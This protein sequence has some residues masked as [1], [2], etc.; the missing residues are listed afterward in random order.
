M[1]QIFK[2]L[3]FLPYKMDFY[4]VK[5]KPF[6]SSSLQEMSELNHSFLVNY[7]L[8]FTSFTSFFSAKTLILLT[9][10]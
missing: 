5:Y 9:A 3:V 1:S 4:I 2:S 7:F 6:L 8:V 10:K